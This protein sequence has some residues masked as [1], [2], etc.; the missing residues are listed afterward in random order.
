MTYPQYRLAA[1]LAATF[2]LSLLGACGE[3]PMPDHLARAMAH[4]PTPLKKNMPAARTMG[5]SCRRG[6]SRWK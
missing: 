3:D 2:L 5:V 4:L 1:L 6:P